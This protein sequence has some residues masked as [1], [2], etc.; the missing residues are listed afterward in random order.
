[1]Q[2][3]KKRAEIGQGIARARDESRPKVGEKQR[4]GDSRQ[5]TADRRQQAAGRGEGVA[6]G[7]SREE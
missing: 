1:L 5:Q 4:K 3:Q 6:R 2:G 7:K